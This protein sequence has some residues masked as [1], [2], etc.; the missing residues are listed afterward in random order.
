MG[1]RRTTPRSGRISKLYSVRSIRVPLIF[2][3]PIV[4]MRLLLTLTSFSMMMPD[5]ANSSIPMLLTFSDPTGTYDVS[6][7]VQPEL[8]SIAKIRRLI[9]STT[10]GNSFSEN[11]S[12]AIGSIANLVA[13]DCFTYLRMSSTTL[14]TFNVSPYSLLMSQSMM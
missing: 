2:L 7:V 12:G 9:Y 8:S 6:S 10:F 3:T 13:P 4:L 1:C 5:A 11:I 14:F